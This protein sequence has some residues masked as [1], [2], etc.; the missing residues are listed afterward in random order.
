ML[1]RFSGQ[2]A[3]A[4]RR[5]VRDGFRIVQFFILFEFVSDS[6]NVVRLIRQFH[7]PNSVGTNLAA[8]K[9]FCSKK[10][11]KL[12]GNCTDIGPSLQF[13][14]LT[15]CC[16][17]LPSILICSLQ[18]LQLTVKPPVVPFFSAMGTSVLSAT[19]SLDGIWIK[20][21]QTNPSKFLNQVISN[22]VL[23]V[24]AGLNSGC[25]S[26]MTR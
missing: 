16:A 10:P 3:L 22:N 2:K 7:F 21:T 26:D 5:D 25:R 20:S 12:I 17:V 24:S 11:C 14:H 6:L 18:T 23:P 13:E 1:G 19:C 4:R 15:T 8:D 9:Q